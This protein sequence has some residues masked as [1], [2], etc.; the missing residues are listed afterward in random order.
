M[1]KE[2]AKKIQTVL[3]AAL[4]LLQMAMVNCLEIHAETVRKEVSYQAVE[5]EGELPQEIT[6]SVL[7]KED[8][9]DVA[10]QAVE[11]LEEASYWQDDFSFPMTFYEYGADTY[12]LGDRVLKADELPVLAAQY[13]EEILTFMGLSPEE[14][15]VTDLVWNGDA[16][17]NEEGVICRDARGVGRR[18]LRDYRVVYE[19]SVDPERWKEL[20]RDS[21]WKAE[22]ETASPVEEEPAPE[23]TKTEE[24][25]KQT[26]T[27]VTIQ[28]ESETETQPERIRSKVQ[29][30]FEKVTQIF[31]VAVGV[32]AL[33]FF[34]GLF[35]LACMRIGRKLREYFKN[36]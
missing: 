2:K 10:C 19:G 21:T 25:Q 13:G 28:K 23:E 11:W 22:T 33:F 12:Q 15:E 18:L 31:L 4:I 17:Q 24:T 29:E 20:R 16:Y 35:V 5:E 27:T 7:A 1:T 6:V 3:W 14:Y 9:E 34:G 8:E 36:R 32:G 26:E 30:F